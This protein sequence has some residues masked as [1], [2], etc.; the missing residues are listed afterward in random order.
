MPPAIGPAEPFPPERFQS[1][2]ESA[3]P[4]FPVDLTNL[5]QL[6]LA[7][8]LAELDAWRRRVNLTG[9]LPSEALVTHALE[10]VL[11]AR[12]VPQGAQ[13]VDVGT[14]GG[15][16]GVPLAI[17]RADLWVTWL[18]P[19]EKRS[20]FLRHV[21]RTLPAENA[22]V[23][24]ARAEDLPDCGFDFATSRAVGIETL[25]AVR[26]LRP[27]GGLILWTTE[28]KA[29]RAHPPGYQLER[30][31]PIPFSRE[32]VIALYLRASECGSDPLRGSDPRI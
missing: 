5:Q 9:R 2:L 16:P 4:G 26:F 30:L 32:R 13:V 17:V 25:G 14:G 12:L 20:A 28:S 21:A 18:E 8:F 10:S 1:L 24:T 22:A 27:P 11:G 7:R 23:L 19:R 3:L 15:F 6:A 31:V 29:A